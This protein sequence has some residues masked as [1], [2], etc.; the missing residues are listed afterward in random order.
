[1]MAHVP[2][3]AIAALSMPIQDVTVLDGTA[4]LPRA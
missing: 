4:A 1:M 3:F 2:F